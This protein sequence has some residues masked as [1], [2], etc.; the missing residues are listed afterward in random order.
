M[1]VGG[2]VAK[3]EFEDEIDEESDSGTPVA[4]GTGEVKKKSTR[5]SRACSESFFLLDPCFS[6]ARAAVRWSTR[7]KISRSRG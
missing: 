5:G 3:L 1:S 2:K 4:N 6:N 7:S